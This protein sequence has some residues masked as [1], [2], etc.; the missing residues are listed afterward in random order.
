MKGFRANS[1]L[2][3]GNTGPPAAAPAEQLGRGYGSGGQAR[4]SSRRGPSRPGTV[5]AS[6][7]QPRG[8]SSHPSRPQP[9]PG[10]RR[11][12][13]STHRHPSRVLP[14]VPPPPSF[15]RTECGVTGGEKS[16]SA[17]G[18][19]PFSLPALP[20]VTSLPWGGPASARP[21]A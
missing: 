8:T 20:L 14:S 19:P 9:R 10:R 1:T 7:H 15:H 11:G 17:S 6:A 18:A 4:R 13:P 2:T 16:A 21:C 5:T 3:R 12:A